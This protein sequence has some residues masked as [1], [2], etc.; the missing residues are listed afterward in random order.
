MPPLPKTPDEYA[1][2]LRRLGADP[3]CPSCSYESWSAPWAEAGIP[4]YGGEIAVHVATCVQCGF[5]RLHSPA[6]LIRPDFEADG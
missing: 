5:M 4:A 2:T 1:A 3:R 6:I